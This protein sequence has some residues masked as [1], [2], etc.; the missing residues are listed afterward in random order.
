MRLPAAIMAAAL[1]TVPALAQTLPPIPL[2]RTCSPV[3]KELS[4]SPTSDASK[5]YL[6][7]KAGPPVAIPQHSEWP[8]SKDFSLPE[9][10]DGKV[11]R[12]IYVPRPKKAEKPQYLA[13]RT[14]SVGSADYNYVALKKQK[15]PFSKE[16][17]YDEYKDYH[18]GVNDNSRILRHYHD[19]HPDR[20][21][22]PDSTRKS[23]NFNSSE[24]F[25]NLFK[26]KKEISVRRLLTIS[27]ATSE[28]HQSCV[29]FSLGPHLA[30]ACEP[31]G[32]DDCDQIALLNSFTIDV[33]EARTFDG[34]SGETFTI[35]YEK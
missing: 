22:T 30:T 34:E 28:D 10:K 16:E 26:K 12:F 19:W 6:L 31:A 14:R 23:Y 7:T 13:I 8:L 3:A 32:D 1:G 11:L 25:T 33:T 29:P 2:D 15:T 18:D 5:L 20:S 4:A 27:F 17:Y 9:Y 21:D 35:R 24:W